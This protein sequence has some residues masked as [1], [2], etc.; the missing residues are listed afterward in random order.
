MRGEQRPQRTESIDALADGRGEAVVRESGF[1]F[2]GDEAGVL[3]E[4][5]MP[6]D[7]RLRDAENT[8][9]LGDVQALG[10]QQSQHAQPHVVPE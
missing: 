2:F 3:E 9:E 10:R 1:A 5:E 4:S 8:G 7:T 6:R